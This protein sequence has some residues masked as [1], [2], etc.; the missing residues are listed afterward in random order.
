MVNAYQSTFIG[1]PGR[2]HRR[3]EPVGNGARQFD[4]L[5]QSSGTSGSSIAIDSSGNVYIA[6]QTSSTDLS[7]PSIPPVRRAISTSLN[8]ISPPPRWST[9]LIWE[10]R[11]IPSIINPVGVTSNGN[12]VL[13]GD[14]VSGS[15]PTLNAYQSSLTG[16]RDAFVTG[17]QPELTVSYYAGTTAT[18]TP[19][20]GAPSAVGTYTVVATF[21]STDPNYTDA[22]SDPVTFTISPGGPVTP[23]GHAPSIR[24]AT[25][26]AVRSRR[27]RRPWEQTANPS[28]ARLPSRTMSV[29]ATRGPELRPLRSMPARTPSWHHLPAPIPTTA[30]LQAQPV[31]FT[32]TPATTATIGQPLP[33]RRRFM[34]NPRR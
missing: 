23:D 3:A 12:I 5:R 29:R 10:R 1:G 17:L 6:G 32:I 13:A 16:F 31:T 7:R 20:P 4:L 11:T 33:P 28:A 34:A 26:T 25:T 15:F 14:T 27:P 9:R 2:L 21:T 18:G 22:Q 19:F 8:S 24:A 30:T